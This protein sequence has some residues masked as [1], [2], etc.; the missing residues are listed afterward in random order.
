MNE[1]NPTTN[2]RPVSELKP[3]PDN[4]RIGNVD[5][6]ADS[7]KK[8]G[9]YAPIVALPDGTVI[10]GSHRLAA[11][12]QLGWKEMLVTTVNAD[13][14]TA[15]R[16]LLADNRTSDLGFYDNDSLQ[17][18]LASLAEESSLD[19]TGWDLDALDDLNALLEESGHVPTNTVMGIVNTETE[20]SWEERK[21]EYKNRGI[22][23]IILDYRLETFEWVATAAEQARAD[24]GVD[25]I[26]D[27]V[28]VLLADHLDIPAPQ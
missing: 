17:G 27:L 24:L 26:A 16:I 25:S 1:L 28:V 13:E 7:F 14:E 6:I 3:H 21:E 19:G 5:V 11:A 23:S 9:Q 15:K 8:N 18:L 4:P 2:N 10:A 12:K 20:Q 22:R